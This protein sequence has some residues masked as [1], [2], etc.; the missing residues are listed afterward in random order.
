M[1]EPI[2]RL[3]IYEPICIYMTETISG[4]P[5]FK[6]SPLPCIILSGTRDHHQWD[7]LRYKL[8]FT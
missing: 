7:V 6:V 8:E 3:Y 4:L 1:Q 2:S 5:L